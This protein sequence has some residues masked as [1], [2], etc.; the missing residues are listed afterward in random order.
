MM[1]A[2]LL[3]TVSW[4]PAVDALGIT[5]TADQRTAA[6]GLGVGLLAIAILSALIRRAR[7][8][9]LAVLITVL[10]TGG[11]WLAQGQGLFAAARGLMP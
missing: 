2:P 3:S 7:R 5:L 1:S 8:V 9:L 10:V 6:I 4:L 11:A